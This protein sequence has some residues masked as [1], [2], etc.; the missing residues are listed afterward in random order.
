MELVFYL[1]IIYGISKIALDLYQIKFISSVSVTDQEMTKLSI[2]HDFLNKSNEYNN[3]KLKVSIFASGLSL[4]ITY[5]IIFATGMDL[6]RSLSE[7]IPISFINNDLKIILVFYLALTLINLPISYYKTFIVEQK[8]GFNKSTKNLFFK[9]FFISTIL[10]LII[11]MVLFKAFQIIYYA[12]EDFWWLYIW[13][14]FIFVNI[15]TAYIFPTLIA[16]LFNK[17]KKLEG[18]DLSKSITDLV[19][20]TGFPLDDLYVMD[21]SKRSSHSN[22]YFTGMFGKKRIV[23]FDTL[24]DILNTGEIKSVLAHEIGH[25]KE[26]HILQSTILL[27]FLSL[28]LLYLFSMFIN[29]I[30]AQEALFTPVTTSYIAIIFMLLSPMILFFIM[31]LLSLFSRKNEY[32]ADNFAKRYA[33]SE[34]LISSLLKL[35]RGNLSLVKSSS[36]YSAF[37]YSHPSVFDRISN[38]ER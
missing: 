24:L 23:F 26:K 28:A 21:G 17:F 4:V 9:D 35:Y 29:T 36:I 1:I 2:D 38:L 3:E 22:A 12:S 19:N 14:L 7:S 27:S 18:G 25:Y 30:L 8:F 20:D 34:D 6:I 37:Y 5:L 16:P 31:P 32:E 11:V 13:I 10:S 33:N 15:L